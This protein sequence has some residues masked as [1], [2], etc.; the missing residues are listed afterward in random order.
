[1]ILIIDTCGADGGVALVQIEAEK[2]TFVQE[3]AIAGRT[4][5]AELVPAI[6]E[7]LDG[8]GL[9]P[10]EMEAVAVV[11]G[12]GSFTGV[13][14]GVSAAK[15]LAEANSLPLM[16]ISRLEVLVRLSGYMGRVLA[17]FDAGRGEFYA[18]LYQDGRCLREMLMTLE[19]VEAAATEAPTA[20]VVC[21]VR[22]ETALAALRPTRLP[23]PMPGDAISI[24]TERWQGKRFEDVSGLDG[25]YLR[26]SDAEI[27][28][29]NGHG[30]P[31]ADG[32]GSHKHGS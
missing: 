13:R 24:V 4:F 22:A 12:P 20:V 15:A 32:D 8:A 28:L 7:L 29:K 17:V 21:E 16:A 6:S 23:A 25:N 26:R 18:G 19:Q 1:M 11:S 31:A 9:K 30:K 5:A 14:I 3:T 10:A 2:S 27:F